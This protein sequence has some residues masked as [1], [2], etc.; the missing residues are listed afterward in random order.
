MGVF[1][2]KFGDFISK[3]GGFDSKIG[4]FDSKIGVFDIKCHHFYTISNSK[5]SLFLSKSPYF[6]PFQVSIARDTPS[7]TRVLLERCASTALNSKLIAGKKALFA[8]MVVDA[9]MALD[10]DLPLEMIGVGAGVAV[11]GWL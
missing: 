3:I 10:E 2:G 5:S 4:V 6:G 11:A 9:V 8:G 1:D 7:E